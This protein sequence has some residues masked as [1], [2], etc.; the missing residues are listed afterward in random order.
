MP[1]ILSELRFVVLR[2]VSCLR[3]EDTPRSGHVYISGVQNSG[4]PP[5]HCDQQLDIRK[6]K[7]ND[8]KCDQRLPNTKLLFSDIRM[9]LYIK[10]W[11]VEW[12]IQ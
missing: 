5:L 3:P 8:T 11:D 2:S 4:L 1:R 9:K 7:L 6:E 10:I 12:H